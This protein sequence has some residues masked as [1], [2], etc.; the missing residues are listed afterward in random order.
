MSFSLDEEVRLYTIKAE[1]EKYETLATLFGILTSIHYLE[2]AYLRDAITAAEYTPACTRLL[3]QYNTIMKQK[4]IKD[5]VSSVEDFMK[6]YRMDSSAALERVKVG[7]PATVEHPSGDSGLSGSETAKWVAETTESFITFMDALKLNLRAK[8]QLHPLLQ[9][10]VTGYARFKGSNDSEA[11]SR[12]VGWLIT[13]NGMSAS[14]TITEE[15]SRQLS[16]DVEHA[17]S[18]FFRSLGGKGT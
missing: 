2:A 17:Y 3:S 13:L 4:V 5:E 1:R 7:V 12:L 6:R 16:F 18:E 15:Q 11:R 10:L 14:E 8:D 9:N